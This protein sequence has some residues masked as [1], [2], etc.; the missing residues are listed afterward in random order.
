MDAGIGGGSRVHPLEESE[1]LR[2]DKTKLQLQRRREPGKD[3]RAQ[4]EIP[5]GQEGGRNP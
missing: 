3:L 2:E 4:E 5:K 1:R